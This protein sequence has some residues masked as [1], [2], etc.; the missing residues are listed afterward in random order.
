MSKGVTLIVFV[1]DGRVVRSFDQP[2]NEGDFGGIDDPRG[3]SRSD[4]RFVVSR[5]DGHSYMKLVGRTEA[6]RLPG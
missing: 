2:R 3:L 5:K 6:T 1:S 4:A